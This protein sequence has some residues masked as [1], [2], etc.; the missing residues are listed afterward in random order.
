ME[1]WK[2]MKCQ[3][4]G[5]KFLLIDCMT[6]ILAE[7]EIK[8]L[9]RME[10]LVSEGLDGII[11]ISKPDLKADV[12]MKVYNPDDR[13]TPMCINGIRCAARYIKE[14]YTQNEIIKVDTDSGII[15]VSAREQGLYEVEGIRPLIFKDMGNIEGLCC[16]FDFA[17]VY[18]PYILTV[19]DDIDEKLLNDIGNKANSMPETFPIGI[20][21]SFVKILNG[22]SIYVRTFER[23][24]I[25]LSLSCSSSM[26]AAVYMLYLQGKVPLNKDIKVYNKGGMVICSCTQMYEKGEITG[27][28]CGDAVFEYSAGLVLERDSGLWGIENIVKADNLKKVDERVQR[29]KIECKEKTFLKEYSSI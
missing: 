21:V 22:D 20:N 10:R 12:K 14:N 11:V 24:G 25:G 27:N 19:T 17:E 18:T 5:N 3:G 6:H 7:Q 29:Q 8:H 9:F 15:H 23:G 28:L 4:S 16:E 1:H 2:V 26:M 13:T